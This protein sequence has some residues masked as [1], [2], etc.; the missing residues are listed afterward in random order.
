MPG[1]EEIK[2]DTNYLA[3]LINPT[4][5]KYPDQPK[6]KKKKNKKAK[7]KKQPE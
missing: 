3:H 2:V 7:K 4:L 1:K 5:G 6:T